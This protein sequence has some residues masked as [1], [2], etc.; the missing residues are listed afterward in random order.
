[1]EAGNYSWV[2]DIRARVA[3]AKNTSHSE[4]EF[5]DALAKLG[6]RIADNS[7]SARRDDWIFSLADEPTKKVSG[8]RLGYTYGKQMLKER[9]ARQSAYHPSPRSEPGNQ[10]PSSRC[11]EPE[12]PQRPEQALRRTRDVRQVRHTSPGG[13]RLAPRS[14]GQARTR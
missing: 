4:G 8:E 6:I 1:M 2:G 9:F 5:L 10:T 11:R 13:L 3:L 7:A 12:R 14:A